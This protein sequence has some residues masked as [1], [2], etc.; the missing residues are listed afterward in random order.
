LESAYDE[1]K[2]EIKK[3]RLPKVE[4]KM[5]N[6][7][8]QTLEAIDQMISNIFDNLFIIDPMCILNNLTDA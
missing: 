1:K 4:S 2:M 5:K 7:F 8:Q 6:E 3:A